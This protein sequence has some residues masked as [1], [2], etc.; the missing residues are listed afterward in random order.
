[1]SIDW[2]LALMLTFPF[3]YTIVIYRYVTGK[4]GVVPG[5]D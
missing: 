1:M 4:Y 3:V 2:S 5:G